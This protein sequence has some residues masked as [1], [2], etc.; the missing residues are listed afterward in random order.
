M[1]EISV[2]SLT[3]KQVKGSKIEELYTLYMK[4]FLLRIPI[5]FCPLMFSTI[6]LLSQKQKHTAVQCF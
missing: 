3:T 5:I 2:K 4:L 6:F 1:N